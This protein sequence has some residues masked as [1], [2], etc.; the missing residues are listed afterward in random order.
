MGGWGG[1]GGVGVSSLSCILSPI[2][3]SNDLRTFL[4]VEKLGK[5]EG[6]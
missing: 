5:K 6:Q 2:L 3:E 1:G 4:R